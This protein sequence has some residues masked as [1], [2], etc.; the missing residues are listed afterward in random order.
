MGYIDT[1]WI[2]GNCAGKLDST[3]DLITNCFFAKYM[4]RSG[5]VS[6]NSLIACTNNMHTKITLLKII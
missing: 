4:G 2:K 3:E 1:I 5:L 6:H